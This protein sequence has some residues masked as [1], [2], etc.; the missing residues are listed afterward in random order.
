M[1]DET[2]N[3]F[4]ITHVNEGPRGYTMIYH[5]PMCGGAAPASKRASFFAHITDE[6]SRR[7]RALGDELRSLEDVIA[8]LGPPTHDQRRG[9]VTHSP[10]CD[11]KPAEVHG[12]RVLVY[13]NLSETANV[14]FTDYGPGRGVHMSL[15]S[16][17]IGPNP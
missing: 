17:Y 13:S 5:C 9:L 11:E 8:K 16:K 2:L 4:H 7:L 3:E 12:Y 1:F 14:R 15:E 6:E 10:E